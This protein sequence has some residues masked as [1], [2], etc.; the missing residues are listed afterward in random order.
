MLDKPGSS[1]SKKT[2]NSRKIK[3]DIVKIK[4]TILPRNTCNKNT[5]KASSQHTTSVPPKSNSAKR[6]PLSKLNTA[7]LLN[8]NLPPVTQFHNA[9]NVN[10][11]S[12]PSPPYKAHTVDTF[13]IRP[14]TPPLGQFYNG[15]TVNPPSNPSP[16]VPKFQHAPRVN[17][18][19]NP[20]PPYKSPIQGCSDVTP[21]FKPSFSSNSTPFPTH[22]SPNLQSQHFSCHTNPSTSQQQLNKG[23]Q[24]MNVHS[25]GVNLLHKF[26]ETFVENNTTS[27]S[28]PTTSKRKKQTDPLEPPYFNLTKFDATDSATFSE[29]D[30]GSTD[31]STDNDDDEYDDV[32]PDSELNSFSGKRYNI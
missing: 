5:S 6:T 12:N 18:P 8:S 10:L 27:P 2:F 14:F 11:S 31:N 20:I 26:T 17:F 15:P 21:H 16:P 4:K 23:K 29:S 9:P 30:E 19:S 28:V 22:D 7:S 24:P 1:E 32:D 25:L 13:N 3:K